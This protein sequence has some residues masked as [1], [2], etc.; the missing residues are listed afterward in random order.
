MRQV[1]RAG[2]RLFV[3]F[4]GKRSHVLAL[5]TGEVMTVELFVSAALGAIGL[6]YAEATI[7]GGTEAKPLNGAAW[8]S[9]S[10][11]T[12]SRTREQVSSFYREPARGNQSDHSKGDGHEHSVAQN[13]H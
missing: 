13:E 4:A 3:D 9:S 5:A 2:Q 7:D 1:R 8:F 10:R 11:T 12:G 6:T